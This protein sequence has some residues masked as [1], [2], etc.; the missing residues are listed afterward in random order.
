MQNSSKPRMMNLDLLRVVAAIS[1]VIYHLFSRNNL[2]ISGIPMYDL[3]THITR[4]GRLA[5]DLFFILSGFFLV[6]TFN[7]KVNLFAYVKKRILRFWPVLIFIIVCNLVMSWF[8]LFK[9]NFYKHLVTFVG[10]SGTGI[11]GSAVSIGR[12]WYVANLMWVSSLLYYLM[13]HVDKR[14]IDFIVGIFTVISYYILC[15]M[16]INHNKLVFCQMWHGIVSVGMLRAIGGIGLGYIIA[17]WY[18]YYHMKCKTVDKGF[19]KT[20]F[21]LVEICAFLLVWSSLFF[22]LFE[23]KNNIFVIG[24]FVSAVILMLMKRGWFSQKLD[25]VNINFLSRY[26]YSLFMC[27]PVVFILLKQFLWKPYP[28]IVRAEP[29]GILLLTLI[30]V[31]LMTLITYHCVEAP[32]QKLLTKKR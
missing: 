4:Q 32:V 26:T 13:L 7:K 1:I 21:T 28:Q 23:P 5:T 22:R 29:V 8:G 6:Y 30:S 10:L 24:L 18:E 16:P 20:I 31:V 11:A 17:R 14:K 15:T 19:N 25:T 12:F 3:L 2:R 27:H 9:F